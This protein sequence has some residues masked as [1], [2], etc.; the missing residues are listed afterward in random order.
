LRGSIS[1]GQVTQDS[2]TTEDGAYA[3]TAQGIADNSITRN[4]GA[5]VFLTSENEWYKAAYYDASSASYFEY[6]TG[7]DAQT[8]CA[9][10]GATENTANCDQVVGDLTDVGSYM[11]SASPTGTFDQGGNVF[12]WNEDIDGGG[13]DRA[14][15]GG[16]W[17]NV[18]GWLA[19]SSRVS[20]IPQNE[21]NYVG[22]RVAMIPACS[23]G[24]DNDGDGFIDFPD[25]PGCLGSLGTLEDP[26][27]NDGIANDTDG[28][29]DFPDD[30]GCYGSWYWT[31]S[32]ECDDGIENDTDGLIDFPDD[33]GCRDRSWDTE[34]PACDDGINNDP[35]QDSLIDLDDP[36][37]QNSSDVTEFCGLGFELVLVLMPLLMWL[38]GRRRHA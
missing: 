11:G 6:P 5:R 1:G 29:I 22:F 7:S 13:T 30:P 36:H 12:E 10:P 38:R 18:A 35:A 19:A 3:I 24:L 33:P 16:G 31:E 27:C 23:D 15:R 26:E 32:P 20:V 9:M 14:L 34:S 21:Y 8:S 4:P 25:D 37:C 2:T 17:S 28:L